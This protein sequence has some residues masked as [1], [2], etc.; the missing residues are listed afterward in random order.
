MNQTEGW[1][2]SA[3]AERCKDSRGGMDSRGSRDWRD[4]VDSRGGDSRG[5]S[6]GR[7]R[8]S[9]DGLARVLT[10]PII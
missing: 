2:C 7:D 5:R 3:K 9:R 10:V 4:S 1:C 6:D 8:D